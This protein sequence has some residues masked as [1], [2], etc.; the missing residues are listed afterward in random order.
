MHWRI[1]SG[2]Y[3]FTGWKSRSTHWLFANQ[4]RLMFPDVRLMADK[5]ITEQ[6]GFYSSGG[7]SSYWSLLLHLVEKHAGRDM[8]ILASKFSRIARQSQSPFAI[9]KDS[10]NMRT[11]RDSVRNLL[12]QLC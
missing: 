9:S 3:W 2:F 7:A 5:I 10:V 12:N 8:A 6:N 4:F 11:N 1:S